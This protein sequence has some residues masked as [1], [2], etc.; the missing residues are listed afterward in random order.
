M[1]S[2]KQCILC[3]HA[4]AESMRNWDVRAVRVLSGQ[5]RHQR[6]TSQACEQRSHPSVE[7]YHCHALRLQMWAFSAQAPCD[8]LSTATYAVLALAASRAV[9]M[10]HVGDAASAVGMARRSR[11]VRTVGEPGMPSEADEP[12][13]FVWPSQRCTLCTAVDMGGCGATSVLRTEP[14]CRERHVSASWI[15]PL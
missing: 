6:D 8:G 11:S 9:I 10:H 1:S 4:G 2:R 15:S 14:R 5:E 12:E 13:N 3:A 7:V